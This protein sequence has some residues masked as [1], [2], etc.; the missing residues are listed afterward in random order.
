M[1]LVAKSLFLLNEACIIVKF[2]Q[3]WATIP[4]VNNNEVQH[5]A[6]RWKRKFSRCIMVETILEDIWRLPNNPDY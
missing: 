3:V 5:G 1:P 4:R 2:H 6:H